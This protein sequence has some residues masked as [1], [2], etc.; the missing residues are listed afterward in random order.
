MLTTLALTRAV[1][2]RALELSFDAVA[3]GPARPP[4]PEE[5]PAA[6]RAGRRAPLAAGA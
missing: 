4:A 3:T 6:T 1:K 5:P 2:S